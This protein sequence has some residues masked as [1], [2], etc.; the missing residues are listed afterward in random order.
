[1]SQ[2]DIPAI[3]DQIAAPISRLFVEILIGI[4]HICLLKDHFKRFDVNDYK[5]GPWRLGQVCSSWRHIV[6]NTPNLWTRLSLNDCR[7][8]KDPVSRFKLALERSS[9][10]ALNLELCPSDR[11]PLDVQ[12][13][14]YQVAIAHSSQWAH[15]KITPTSLI[16]PFLSEIRHHPLH[17]LSRL[18]VQCHDLWTPLT[19]DAFQFASALRIVE[20][21]TNY[22]DV[23]FELPWNHIVEF[24]DFRSW[25]NAESIHHALDIIRQS[26]N[27]QKLHVPMICCSPATAVSHPAP[28]VRSNLRDLTVC[29]G[30]ILRSLVV[31]QLQKICLAPG[32]DTIQSWPDD[33]LPALLDLIQRSR[34]SLTSLELTDVIFTNLLIDILHCTPGIE[35]LKLFTQCWES[36]YDR[37][38]K[39]LI[40]CLV[41]Y[42]TS[43]QRFLP[44]L[45]N[46]NITVADLLMEDSCSFIDHTFFH[47]VSSRWNFGVLSAVRLDVFEP[48]EGLSWGLTSEHITMFRMFKNNGMDIRLGVL[49]RDNEAKYLCPRRTKYV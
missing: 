33:A 2:S 22:A 20:L 36:V 45:C 40:Q 6:N 11:Y 18:I 1:M 41:L 43:Q 29:E 26:P 48:G 35:T 19:I 49:R 24:F 8:V 3:E 15:L 30:T 21:H 17:K 47:M 12:R 10:L 38:F 42:P 14:I 16:L 28:L 9:C 39:A 25:G 34:C 27:I 32:E 23:V 44:L 37:I 7:V 4:F 5:R 13:E 46:L 31:P